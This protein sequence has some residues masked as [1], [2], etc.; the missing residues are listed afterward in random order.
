MAAVLAPGKL[1][2]T[3][4]NGSWRVSPDEEIDL[5][6]AE[7]DQ[8]TP[9]LYNSGAAA[10]AWRRLRHTAL[11][12]SSATELL[13]Q[14]YRY[15]ALF[16][17][18][19]ESKLQKTFR[20]LRQAGVEPILIKGWA[21]SRLYPQPGLRPSGDIDLFVRPD[22]YSTVLKVMKSEEG[23]DCWIDLHA[24]IFELADR[25]GQELFAR[26]ELHPCGDESVRI[27]CLEDHFALLAVHL[28]KHGAW[29][30]LWLCDLG[31][32]LES[33]PESF[34]WKLCLGKSARRAN[35]ILSSISLA[36]RLVGARIGNDE[37]AERSRKTPSWLEPA[38]L[39]QW[40]TPFWEAHESLPLLA[41]YLRRPFDF[42]REVPNRWPD[43]IV[44]TINVRGKF[45]NN[46]RVAYQVCEMAARTVKF[47][48]SLPRRL[49]PRQRWNSP[50]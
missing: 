14:A 34:D 23:R 36:Q 20:L 47:F 50:T 43:P 49:T 4:L 13:H 16:A 39:K 1:I 5:C 3:I 30:P 15:Q 6:A 18:T 19:H 42:V 38:V 2:S 44:A 29:R 25:A 27:L 26:S 7:L 10:L 31:L 40:E 8:V 41:G 33:M 22:D 21:V 28:L 48:W 12:D 32:L 9:L 46:P 35:W 37:I 24:R 45:N 17:A 11:R